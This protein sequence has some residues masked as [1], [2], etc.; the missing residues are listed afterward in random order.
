VTHESASDFELADRVSRTDLLLGRRGAVSSLAETNDW[1]Q[2]RPV[3]VVLDAKLA[4]GSAG[5][6]A[7]VTLVTLLHRAGFPVFVHCDAKE[8]I[9]TGPFKGQD[10]RATLEE[11][12][13]QTPIPAADHLTGTRAVLIGDVQTSFATSVQLTWDGWIAG[14]RNPR[15]RMEEREGCAL[16]P[17]LAAALVV[18][19]I[20][21]SHLGVIDA[22]WRDV[23]LSLWNPTGSA[24]LPA[25]GPTLRW[26]PTQWML[27]GL[28]HLGQANA[29]C[30]SHLPYESDAGEIW[31]ADDDFVAPANLSTGVLTDPRCMY[32]AS[33]SRLRKTRT[34]AEA[35][36]R[37]G[38]TTRM[39]ERR[40]H[41]EERFQADLPAIALVGVDN[42]ETRRTL[43]DFGWPLCVDA[44]LGSTPSSF[45]SVS[46]HTFDG[47]GQSSHDVSA[48]RYYETSSTDT[49]AGI[50][51]DL[52]RAGLDEC[53]VVTLANKKVA[54]AYVGMIAGCLVVAEV[55]RRL[56]GGAGSSSISATLDAIVFRGDELEPANLRVQLLE[57]RL[58]TPDR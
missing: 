25:Q 22:C 26:L 5:Q 49:A 4:A 2:Q 56:N 6:A 32:D 45:D 35:I 11:L 44:G 42:L 40:L 12:G 20:L 27:I 1:F 33:G 53:G 55:L 16:A 14:V 29:W 50:F 17:L 36:E 57:A 13:A 30:L 8:A 3:H 34:V 38:R 31:L 37:S 9:H 28:G 24:N 18:S 46:V 23:T 19:E 7:A 51:E 15:S 52:R 10:L 47:S 21:E 39:I 54:C 58:E 41:S 48:W 43:S